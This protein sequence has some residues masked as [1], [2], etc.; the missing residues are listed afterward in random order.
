MCQQQWDLYMHE[1]SSQD[2]IT[3]QGLV[4]VS[5]LTA[6]KVKNKTKKLTQGHMI[7]EGNQV[8][9]GQ[10]LTIPHAFPMEC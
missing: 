2:F 5:H 3:F 7:I 10:S 8:T 4:C 9:Q 6:K 1:K